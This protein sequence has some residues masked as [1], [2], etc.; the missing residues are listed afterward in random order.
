MS[1]F[2]DRLE[3][4][5]RGSPAPMG[6]GKAARVE[7]TPCMALLGL[8]SQR[9]VELAPLLAQVGADG[10]LIEGVNGDKRLKQIGKLLGELPWGVSAQEL[11]EESA[12]R[13]R[14]QGCDFFAFSPDKAT[15]A[16]LAEDGP[17]YLLCIPSDLDDRSLRAIEGL[18]VDAVVLALD[19]DQSPLNLQHLIAIG[20][21]RSM[22]DKYLLLRISC[23]I[24]GGELK[25]LRDVGV[26]GLV[27]DA[28]AASEEVLREL[29]ENLMDLPRQ[30][31]PSSPKADAMLPRSAY[32]SP[33]PSSLEEEDD[34]YEDE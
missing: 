11:S 29:R 21:I 22:F 9:H 18:P 5:N 8:L 7:K 12:R 20:S 17:A 4:I 28:S 33:S 34:D 26:D 14:D 10:V 30:R 2:L 1:K 16:A 27:V 3:L 15:L 19:Q 24:E 23:P 6:F 25:A 31:K 32:R 13:Y